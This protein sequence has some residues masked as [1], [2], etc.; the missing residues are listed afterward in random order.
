MVSV[1]AG[2][3]AAWAATAQAIRRRSSFCKHIL[4]Q[5]VTVGLVVVLFDLM[6]GFHRWSFNYVIPL[7]CTLTMLVIAAIAVT[8]HRMVSNYI[9]YM[10]LSAVFGIVPILFVL[11]HW[12]DVLWPTVFTAA[13]SIIYLAG[14]LLFIGRD[15][16][17]ELKKRLHL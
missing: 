12:T 5:V 3:G 2:V 6:T 4:Y 11:F 14:L 1:L 7:M 15:T 9:I 13:A 17:S 10:V 8:G 16:V